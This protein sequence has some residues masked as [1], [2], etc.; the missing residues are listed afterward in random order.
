[1]AAVYHLRSKN[2]GRFDSAIKLFEIWKRRTTARAVAPFM[3][4]MQALIKQAESDKIKII[5]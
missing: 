2:R 4:S 5:G 3:T 1:M